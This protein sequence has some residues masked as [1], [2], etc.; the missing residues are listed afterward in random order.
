MIEHKYFLAFTFFNLLYS[1]I[2]NQIEIVIIFI[3]IFLKSIEIDW[4]PAR[5]PYN[6]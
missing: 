1:L 2:F 6:I 4:K 5:Q 3:L